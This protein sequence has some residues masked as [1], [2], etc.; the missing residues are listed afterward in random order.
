M[1]KSL[2]FKINRQP[3]ELFAKAQKEAGQYGY[4]LTGDSRQGKIS[5]SGIEGGYKFGKAGLVLTIHQK[6]VLLSWAAIEEKLKGFLID[7]E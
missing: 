1:S 4:T 2:H 7:F 3:A 5:G 6:P